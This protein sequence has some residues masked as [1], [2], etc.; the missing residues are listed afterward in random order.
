VV[1]YLQVKHSV[2]S[3]GMNYDAES[4]VRLVIAELVLFSDL[5]SSSC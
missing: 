5:V 2:L 1:S 4:R 3:A